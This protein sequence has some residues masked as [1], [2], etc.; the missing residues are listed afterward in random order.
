M[1]NFLEGS[2]S[3]LPHQ[4][5]DTSNSFFARIADTVEGEDPERGL[6]YAFR[7]NNWLRKRGL[8]LPKDAKY[9][10]LACG[11]GLCER[12]FAMKLGIDDSRT[13][14]L[15]KKFSDEALRIMDDNPEIGLIQAGI[16][17]FLNE[18]KQRGFSVVSAFGVDY[19]LDGPSRIGA[20]IV[21]LPKILMPGGF[22]SVAPYSGKDIGNIWEDNGFTAIERDNYTAVMHFQPQSISKP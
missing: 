17:A 14:L 18:P 6:S 1:S 5:D 3:Y 7:I 15:D 9:L 12:V 10:G 4:Y 21:A 20:L 2:G 11:W 16:F 8:S 22:V 19:L 13:T